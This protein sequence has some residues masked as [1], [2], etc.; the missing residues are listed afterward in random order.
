[1]KTTIEIEKHI[2]CLIESRQK[3]DIESSRYY[4]EPLFPKSSFLLTTYNNGQKVKIAL[5]AR[6]KKRVK[7][8]IEGFGFSVEG[9]DYES[10]TFSF[11]GEF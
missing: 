10:F 1:M 9:S 7:S 6:S 5:S 2:K 3:F 8:V 4:Y 11:R